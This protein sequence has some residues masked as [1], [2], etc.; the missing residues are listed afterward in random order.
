MQFSDASIYSLLVIITV[1]GI[2][3]FIFAFVGSDVNLKNESDIDLLIKQY[4][5]LYDEDEIQTDHNWKQEIPGY[6][7][8]LYQT[9]EKQ[10]TDIW[11]NSLIFS[12]TTCIL[13][14]ALIASL[15]LVH[16]EHF[17]DSFQHSYGVLQQQLQYHMFITEL[18]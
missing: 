10:M 17:G 8:T 5:A 7:V 13:F 2:A 16:Q 15:G 11:I 4:E 3:F 12:I 9:M 14:L 18:S 1:I 6:M